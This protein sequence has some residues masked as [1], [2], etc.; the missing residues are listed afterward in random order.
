MLGMAGVCVGGTGVGSGVN[1]GTGVA[2]G[3][4]A[5]NGVGDGDKPTVAVAAGS[6]AACFGPFPFHVKPYQANPTP[7]TIKN[8]HP[9]IIHRLL[10]SDRKLV[11]L[12]MGESPV[13]MLF[14]FRR[15]RCR[16]TPSGSHTIA[17]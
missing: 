17:R 9:S 13:W 6:T 4:S 5:G 3:G 12:L 8:P 14:E 15:H 7:T 16:A 2:V 11:P 10:R 1:V